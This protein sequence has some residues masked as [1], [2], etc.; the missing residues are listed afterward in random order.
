MKTLIDTCILVYLIDAQDEKRHSRTVEWFESIF[1]SNEY[2]IST[3]NLREF[4]FVSKSKKKVNPEQIKEYVDLFAK[5]FNLISDTVS[6]IKKASEKS[7]NKYWDSLLTATAKRNNI[8][9]IITENEKDFK[10]EIQTKNI[11][12]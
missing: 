3:Q 5:S 4:A 10:G 7:K 12:N 9:Q 11:F 1:E 6:D 2:F 8:F